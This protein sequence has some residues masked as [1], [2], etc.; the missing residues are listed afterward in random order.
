MKANVKV[1]LISEPK[2]DAAQDV[3]TEVITNP[4]DNQ[5]KILIQ[6]KSHAAAMSLIQ[7]EADGNKIV[8][9]LWLENGTD[10]LEKLDDIYTLWMA[11]TKHIAGEIGFVREV[12]IAARKCLEDLQGLDGVEE[13]GSLH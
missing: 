4:Y 10:E 13:E 5:E 6:F 3:E 1:A 12:R 8:E 9:I 2:S 11:M 7:V